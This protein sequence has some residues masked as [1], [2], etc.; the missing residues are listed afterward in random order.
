MYD[1]LVADATPERLR[2]IP[3]FADLGEETLQWVAASCSELDVPEGHTVVQ[4]REPATGFFLIEDGTVRVELRGKRRDLGPGDFFGEL[5]LLVPGENRTAR[6]RSTSRVRLLCIDRA[7]FE[8]LVATEPGIGH[9]LARS[10]AQRLLHDI[11]D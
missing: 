10:L 6:V 8:R 11:P 9:G 5:A 4:P 1:S 7:T 2:A 3:L